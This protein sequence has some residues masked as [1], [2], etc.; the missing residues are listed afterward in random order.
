MASPRGRSRRAR[1]TTLGNLSGATEVNA[2]KD[3]DLVIE[4][5]I[6]NLDEKRTTYA[7]LEKVV[8]DQT[9]VLSP[10]RWHH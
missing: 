4:A 7:A 10:R 9:I 1:D 5:I 3:R 2:L 8:G 6:E